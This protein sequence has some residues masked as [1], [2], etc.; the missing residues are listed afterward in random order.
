MPQLIARLSPREDN[1]E[2]IPARFQAGRG[3]ALDGLAE[4]SAILVVARPWYLRYRAQTRNQ[5]LPLGFGFFLR[6]G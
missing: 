3:L 4:G 6:H 1:D 5:G 2:R